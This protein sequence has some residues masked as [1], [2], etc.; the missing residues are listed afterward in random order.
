MLCGVVLA[1]LIKE[2]MGG[3][4]TVRIWGKFALGL[5]F[6]ERRILHSDRKR[7]VICRLRSLFYATDDLRVGGN[8]VCRVVHRPGRNVAD[9]TY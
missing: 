9:Y 8:G 2:S 4:R 1:W 7:P 5:G 3:N 6:D